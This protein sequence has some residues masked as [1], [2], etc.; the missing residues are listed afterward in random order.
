MLG[1][2]GL[3]ASRVVGIRWLDDSM[4]GKGLDDWRLDDWKRIRWWVVLPHARRS[5]RSAD[6]KSIGS[7]RRDSVQSRR[8]PP[9]K[10]LRIFENWPFKTRVKCV[11]LINTSNETPTSWWQCQ[12]LSCNL[13]SDLL[14]FQPLSCNLLCNF[15]KCQHLSCNLLRDFLEFQR[16]WCNWFANSLNVNTSHAIC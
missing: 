4:I 11:M 13:L 7:G 1:A 10:K 6:Y 16:F 2:W 15:G 9:L 3:Q 12:H 8:V 14:E 5:E